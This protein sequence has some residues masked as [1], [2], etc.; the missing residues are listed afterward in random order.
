M[1]THHEID[2]MSPIYQTIH[3]CD[4]SGTK[5][6][7]FKKPKYEINSNMIFY[8]VKDIINI[9]N[10][11]ALS[12]YIVYADRY[13]GDKI[14][15]K[16]YNKQ[17]KTTIISEN[18]NYDDK[19]IEYF[20]F[21]NKII[22][23][24]ECNSKQQNRNIELFTILPEQKKV[25]LENVVSMYEYNNKIFVELWDD[26]GYIVEIYDDNLNLVRR[27]NEY[28]IKCLCDNN[29]AILTKYIEGDSK[30]YYYNV[31]D[32]TITESNNFTGWYENMAIEY[33]QTCNKTV[34]KS[35]INMPKEE[36]II[37]N[38]TDVS[39]VKITKLIQENEELKR[40]NLEQLELI[41][42]LKCEFPDNI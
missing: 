28:H 14:Y 15:I 18:V 22:F 2:S 11:S 1:E 26:I 30:S 32:D 7:K 12:K 38:T 19:S 25:L 23:K 36:K 40:Q 6:R 24:L 8:P 10:I 4:L 35:F 5:N 31:N 13:P 41:N 33:D 27:L 34:F 3:I 21:N 29:Y 39:E 42:K 20:Y 37:E 16:F 9:T 17:N